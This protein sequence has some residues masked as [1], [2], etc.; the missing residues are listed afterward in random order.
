MLG[1]VLMMI[2][3]SKVVSEGLVLSHF[4]KITLA[5]D[6]LVFM[7]RIA[8]LSKPSH[9]SLH[10]VRCCRLRHDGDERGNVDGTMNTGR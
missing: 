1:S 8:P 3:K 4:G 2:C 5:V 6:Q 9:P 7:V 10:P